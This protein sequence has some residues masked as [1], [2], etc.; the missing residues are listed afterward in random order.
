MMLHIYNTWWSRYI[1]NT[2]NSTSKT[3][4]GKRVEMVQSM[5]D[6][7]GTDLRPAYLSVLGFARAERHLVGRPFGEKVAPFVATWTE[8]V[9]AWLDPKPTD[10]ILDIGAGEGPL[11]ARIAPHVKRSVGI[12]GSP[13]MVEHFKKAYPHIES[14]VVDY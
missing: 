3:G 9:L 12:D 4:I 8:K 1:G 10:E 14:R 11:T 6:T 13:N 2:S 5:L 7:L